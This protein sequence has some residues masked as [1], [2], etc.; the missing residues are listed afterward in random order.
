MTTCNPVATSGN[1]LRQYKIDS[2]SLSTETSKLLILNLNAKAYQVIICKSQWK[3][4]FK[5]ILLKYVLQDSLFWF[6][7]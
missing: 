6:V 3:R 1:L 7:G 4:W 5:I 2:V